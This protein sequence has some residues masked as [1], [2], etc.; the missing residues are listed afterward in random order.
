MFFCG[1]AV[2]MVLGWTPAGALLRVTSTFAIRSLLR[3]IARHLDAAAASSPSGHGDGD[4]GPESD[5]EKRDAEEERARHVTALFA[6]DALVYR[7]AATA[8]TSTSPSPARPTLPPSASPPP[9]TRQLRGSA[10]APRVPAP[11]Q[12]QPSRGPALPTPLDAAL[13][14]DGMYACDHVVLSHRPLSGFMNIGYWRV[15]PGADPAASSAYY[16]SSS[17][18]NGMP[19]GRVP[20]PYV[21]FVTACQN[22]VR[23]AAELGALRGAHVVDCGFGL[24]DQC[25]LL[26]QEYRCSVTGFTK[27]SLQAAIARQR[28]QALGL[29]AH[30]RL[31]TGDAT[32]IAA[33]F[34]ALHPPPPATV[35][36]VVSIDSAYHYNPRSAFFEQAYTLLSSSTTS[37][38]STSTASMHPRIVLADLIL[39]ATWQGRAVARVL[40][41]PVANLGGV[42]EYEAALTAAGFTNVA[43][44]DISHAV[45]PGLTEFLTTEPA[46]AKWRAAG[47]VWWWVW[48]FGGAQFVVARG[49]VPP[50]STRR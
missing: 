20:P 34:A 39:P 2:G 48:K 46:G 13:E 38:T 37:T 35:D 12:Q 47:W 5:P 27:S 49:T 24:G 21:D 17:S 22:L 33:S 15:L 29:G 26:H 28:V 9:P 23:L 8:A 19:Y 50:T 43:I 3:A 16:P 36:A 1:L 41:I 31:H 32:Q 40:G 11:P 7:G 44:H 45:F 42:L 25:L 14:P 18:R 30:I 10:V 6:A 4:G